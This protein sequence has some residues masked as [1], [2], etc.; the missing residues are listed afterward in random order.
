MQLAVFLFLFSSW[1][2]NPR[3]G[4]NMVHTGQ[5]LCQRRYIPILFFP[6]CLFLCVMYAHL[7]ENVYGC[8]ACMSVRHMGA[9]LGGKK[10]AAVPWNCF[11]DAH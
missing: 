6:P 3:P 7:N 1:V 2:S 4:A 11:T 10:R 8:F 9:L 5:V